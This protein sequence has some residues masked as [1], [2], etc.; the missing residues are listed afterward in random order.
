M[1]NI[2]ILD[3]DG[4]ELNP[5]TEQ[6]YSDQYKI[7]S[8]KWSKLP[9]YQHSN[10]IISLLDKNKVVLIISSTGSGKTVLLPKLALHHL[11]YKGRVVV[12]MPKQ[13]IVKAAAEYAAATLDVTL[14]KEIGYQYRGEGK[15]SNNTKILYATDGTLVSQ[16]MKDPLIKMYDVVIIDEAHERKIQID[17]LLF[18][19]KNALKQRED[20]KLIIMSATINEKIFA[21]YYSEFRYT[22]FNVQGERIYPIKSV[23]TKTPISENDYLEAG[24]NTIKEIVK[25][26]NLNSEGSHDILFFV[27]SVNDTLKLCEMVEKDNLDLYCVR[28]YSGIHKDEQFIAQDKSKYKEFGKNRKLVMATNVAESSITIDGIKYVID[29]GFE[30]LSSYDPILRARRLDKKMIT[31]AQ[32]KQRMGRAGRTEPGICYHLYTKDQFE[33]LMEKFPEPSI[34]T[35]NLLDECVRL[36]GL[37]IIGNIPTLKSILKQ[38]IEP[39]LPEYI[40]AAVTQMK[41][42]NLIDT[43]G[44]PTD[45]CK[46]VIDLGTETNVAVT[47]IAGYYYNCYREVLSIYTLLELCHGKLM[48]VFA[49]PGQY[50]DKQLKNR[51]NDAFK[52]FKDSSGDHVSLL[53]IIHKYFKLNT[54][55]S[56]S[57]KNDKIKWCRKYF[58]KYDLL[59]DTYDRFRSISYRVGDILRNNKDV[60][61]LDDD[62]QNKSTSK[63]VL[64][65]IA[66]GFRNQIATK[67]NNMYATPHCRQTWDI[68]NDTYLNKLPKK[69]VYHEIFV[70][71]DKSNLNI[72]SKI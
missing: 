64:A 36:L 35:S 63:R 67:K 72:V 25:N 45:L 20:L 44:N 32:A 59:K 69:I 2:G 9:A 7:L 15:H 3:P 71:G 12:T 1:K 29:S 56:N 47:L 19:L 21:E 10:E 6:P 23:F 65:A 51:F 18:L 62:I 5:L 60:L 33:R 58:L 13:M 11:N 22:S 41:E 66:Y 28:V 30:F 50:A 52:S 38:F 43:S 4:N 49:K 16:L 42:L 27:P 48:D 34:R 46:V 55:E 26:D 53:K 8:K 24:Y 54:K 31:V 70:S 37:E 61:K 39:P 40:D 17:L 14:G 57:D 68:S